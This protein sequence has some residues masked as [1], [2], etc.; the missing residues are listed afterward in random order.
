LNR[1]ECNVKTPPSRGFAKSRLDLI[2]NERQVIGNLCQSGYNHS[3]PTQNVNLSD[4]QARFIRQSVGGG[5]YRNASEV[6]RAALRLLELRER[7]DKL[8]LQVL[9][10]MA[11]DAF[12]DI[13]AGKFEIVGPDGLD[14]FMA[15]IDARV[16]AARS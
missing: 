5:D 6:V 1:H 4:K 2:R 8:K 14:Q 11:K 9:R 12:A 15:K 10:R 7:E 16:R 13:D 3:M